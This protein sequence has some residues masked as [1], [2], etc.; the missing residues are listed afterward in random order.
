LNISD[1]RR[2]IRLVCWAVALGV[3]VA[4]GYG[5]VPVLFAELDR[6]TAGHLA[7]LLLTGAEWGA[8]ALTLAGALAGRGRWLAVS[9]LLLMETVQLSWLNP[10]MA[11]LKRQ[12]MADSPRFYQLHGLSQALYLLSV[13]LLFGLI[14]AV[15][16]EPCDPR[17]NS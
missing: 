8:L 4:M 5:A 10:A 11:A 15:V 1:R 12:M 3:L 9:L 17:Q 13:L 14:L 16:R 7:G 6:R 2:S